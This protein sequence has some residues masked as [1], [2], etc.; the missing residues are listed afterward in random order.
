M[1]YFFR[2]ALG[3]LKKRPGINFINIFGLSL[4]MTVVILLFSYCYRKL[5]TY[6]YHDNLN[7]T[8]LIKNR[9]QKDYSI[10]INVPGVLSD[11]PDTSVYEI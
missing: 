11:H 10:G 9:D 8:Y 4:S 3:N 2:L 1:I 7:K 5:I 6:N